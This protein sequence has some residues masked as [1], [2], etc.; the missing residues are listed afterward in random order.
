MLQVTMYTTNTGD[1]GRPQGPASPHDST[2]LGVR[3]SRTGF[4]P[5]TLGD[6]GQHNQETWRALTEMSDGFSGRTDGARLTCQ[7]SRCFEGGTVMN[8]SLHMRR[9]SPLM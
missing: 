9:R 7:T 2:G 6:E 1:S 5:K 3:K 8:G 4:R